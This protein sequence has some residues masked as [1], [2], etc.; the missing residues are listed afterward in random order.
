LASYINSW[1]KHSAFSSFLNCAST[2]GAGAMTAK[3]SRYGNRK[4]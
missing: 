1:W 4:K 3:S 2:A